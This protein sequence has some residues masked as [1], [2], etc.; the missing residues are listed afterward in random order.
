MPSTIPTLIAEQN[1]CSGW[2]A[3]AAA[4]LDAGQGVVEGEEATADAGGAGATIGLQHVAVD[5]DLTFA[6]HGHVAR[7]SQRA[8]DQ[9]LDLDGAPALLALGRFA[10]DT[11]GRRSGQHRVLG[12]DPPLAVA[13]H[14]A[15]DVLVDRGG[16][17]HPRLA[18]ADQARA[19]GHLGEVSFEADRAEFVDIAAVGSGHPLT[20]WSDSA[21]Q[22]ESSGH[23]SVCASSGPSSRPPSSRN[24]SMSP[25]D[26]KRWAPIR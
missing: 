9:A 19:I 18:E 11:F 4:L 25:L 1:E 12:G 6:Q 2:A 24:W 7:R 26:R 17:Q 20:L 14:P 10:T 3:I 5:D 23:R 15:R 8:P 21:A 22:V 13:A 16:A